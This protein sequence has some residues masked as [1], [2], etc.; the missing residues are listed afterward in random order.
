[1]SRHDL[2]IGDYALLSNC[3]SA[4]LVS[5]GGSVD[6]VCFPRFDRPSV[7]A[8]LLDATAGHWSIRPVGD[9]QTSR[10]YVEDTMLLQTTF[11]TAT[12]VAT[13]VDALAVGSNDRGHQLG[14]GSTSALLRRASGVEGEVELEFE[15]APRP[16]YGLIQPVLETV[17]GG[18]RTRGGADVLALSSPIPVDVEEF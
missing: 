2:P 6:W 5:K 12:G 11:H 17:D 7:F 14:A 10:I 15:F 8:R 1:M 16:E 3:R 13:L 4:A 9:F 18:I